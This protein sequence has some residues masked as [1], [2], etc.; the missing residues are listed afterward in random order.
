MDGNCRRAVSLA[1]TAENPLAA[2]FGRPATLILLAATLF[3]LVRNL[4][5]WRKKGR[6]R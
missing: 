4:P 6:A 2:L 5:V 1:S 3:T